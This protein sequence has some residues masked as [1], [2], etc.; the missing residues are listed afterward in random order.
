MH[1]LCPPEGLAFIHRLLNYTCV[2]YQYFGI[3]V[4]HLA[5][6]LETL[7]THQPTK[8]QFIFLHRGHTSVYSCVRGLFYV[9]LHLLLVEPTVAQSRK[10]EMGLCGF[11]FHTSGTEA[12]YLDTKKRFG[13][14]I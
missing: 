2:S 9:P 14:F 12:L 10:A 8:G 3:S 1:F 7:P 11:S 6:K 13:W 4:C 5:R